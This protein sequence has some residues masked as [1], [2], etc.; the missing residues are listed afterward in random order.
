VSDHVHPFLSDR[1]DHDT[2]VKAARASHWYPSIGIIS[3][4][5]NGQPFPEPGSPMPDSLLDDLARRADVI[6]VGP[7]DAESWLVW[8]PERGHEGSREE[9]P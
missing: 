2:I 3:S 5:E 4:L 7:Y 1:S 6:V 9:A 8:H